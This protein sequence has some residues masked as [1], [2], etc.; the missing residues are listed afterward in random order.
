M[1]FETIDFEPRGGHLCRLLLS[2]KKFEPG[3]RLGP[4]G[5]FF[6][7]LSFGCDSLRSHLKILEKEL[8]LLMQS[9]YQVGSRCIAREKIH[10]SHVD[11][12]NDQAP[13]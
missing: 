13:I 9:I 7:S 5:H 1:E 4:L 8:C 12:E 11:L 3:L 2:L 6:Q 10:A